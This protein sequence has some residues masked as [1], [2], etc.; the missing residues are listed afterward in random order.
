MKPSSKARSVKPSSAQEI[1]VPVDFSPASRAVLAHAVLLARTL[2]ARVTVMNV[3]EPPYPGA[4]NELPGGIPVDTSIPPV[5]LARRLGRFAGKIIPP[6]LAGEVLVGHG[7]AGQTIVA[8]ARQRKSRLIVCATHG[9]SGFK[10]LM[11]GSTAEYLVRHS[12]CPI[13]ALRRPSPRL[14]VKRFHSVL[15]PIDLSA[16]SRQ[17]S[18]YAAGLTAKLRGRLTLL[19]VVPPIDDGA[20]SERAAGRSAAK[21]EQLAKKLRHGGVRVATE[22]TQGATT[23]SILAAAATAD[24]IVIATHGRSGLGRILLGSTAESVIRQ[25]PCPVLVVRSAEPARAGWYNP[26]L[27]F[28]VA[29]V[30]P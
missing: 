4:L 17:A 7:V 20:A 15:A 3:D 12:P 5:K 24:L 29:P 9:Y 1:L 13:L 10:R 22:V 30:M 25:A 8:I 18:T 19:H 23:P 21:L 11:L 26:L 2:A 16:P 27:W 28:P 6:A 14:P